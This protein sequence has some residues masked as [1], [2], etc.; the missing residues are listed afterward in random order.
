[1]SYHFKRAASIAEALALLQQYGAAAMPVAGGT[2]FMPD[3]RSGRARPEVVVDIARLPLR[4][5]RQDAGWVR[6]GAL[7]TVTD[8][9]R[10]SDL[11]QTVQVLASAAQTFAGHLVRNRATVGGNLCDASPAA[12]LA[13]PLL[14]LGAEVALAGP[15]GTARRLPLAE[16]LA[17]VRK[18]ARRTNELVTEIAFPALPA[19][20]RS[21]YFKFALREAMA[22]SVV[23]GAV[24]LEF[25][26]EVCTGARVALGAVA[27]TAVRAASVE[28]ELVG[29]RITDEVATAAAA[30]VSADIRPI[31]DVRATAE[32]RTWVAEAMVR[33][34]I[35]AACAQR[36]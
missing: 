5:I 6:I 24:V 3:F 10:Q 13:P 25:D 2:N 9:L 4:Y 22:I 16:F 8:L 32:Y 31:S 1:M 12:D 11:R 26:D 7:T 33:R 36:V 28:A 21:S 23:S 18:T 19:T 15:G 17:G 27:P 30:K 14:A 29:R 20:A 35:L 34:H